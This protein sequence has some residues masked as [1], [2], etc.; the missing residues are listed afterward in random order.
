MHSEQTR[1]FVGCHLVR[2]PAEYVLVTKLGRRCQGHLLLQRSTGNNKAVPVQKCILVVKAS[3]DTLQGPPVPTIRD[4]ASVNDL[5]C[6][7]AQAVQGYHPSPFHLIHV[8]KH[9]PQ[10]EACRGQVAVTEGVGRVPAHRTELPSLA[11]DGVEDAEAVEQL[12]PHVSLLGTY[13]VLV[14]KHFRLQSHFHTPCNVGPHSEGILRR[15]L[16]T[17]LQNPYGEV[18]NGKTRQEQP[19]ALAHAFLVLLYSRNQP[20]KIVHPSPGQVH[21]LQ[22][23]PVAGPFSAFYHCHCAVPLALS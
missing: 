14:V 10:R 21:V 4:S 2:G 16:D 5:P 3:H 17:S 12:P 9:P 13:K 11:Y 6:D 23:H 7:K 15:N 22:Q 19:E 18:V 20:L 8:L 1:R